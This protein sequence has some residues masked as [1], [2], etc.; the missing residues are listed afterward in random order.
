MQE[1][2]EEED[3]RRSLRE[4]K[5]I[6]NIMSQQVEQNDVRDFFRIP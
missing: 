4:Q 1:E 2:E 6:N 3:A 5:L